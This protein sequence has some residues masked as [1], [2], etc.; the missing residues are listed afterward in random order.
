MSIHERWRLILDGANS[1]DFNMR[2]DAELLARAIEGELL[3]TLRFFDWDRPTITIGYGQPRTDINFAR[4]AEENIAWAVRPTG[5]RAVLHWN[6]LT[7]SVTLPPEHE[8]ARLSVIES[9]RVLS[10]ALAEGLRH[11]GVD[12]EIARGEAGGHKNPS[13]FSSTSRYEVTHEGR[14]LIG[15]AQR[16]KRGAILQQG[17]IPISPEFRGLPKFFTNFVGADLAEKSTCI[18]ECA[19]AIPEK[20]DL[21][22]SIARAFEDGFGITFDELA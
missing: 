19:V 15:S 18:A 12:V 7:Y 13:C 9:Y 16:R 1:G 8:I 21:A 2:K 6:E 5:G 20:A 22:R 4:L 10:T 14:K 11:C 17:S 3:P